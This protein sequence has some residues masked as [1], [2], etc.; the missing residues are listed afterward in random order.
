M[1]QGILWLRL[2]SICEQ[3]CGEHVELHI[4]TQLHPEIRGSVL[5]SGPGQVEILLN[6]ANAKDAD[7]VI[8]TLAHELAHLRTDSPEHDEAFYCSW[9]NLQETIDGL[10]A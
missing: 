9:D 6:A 3:L 5:R 2:Q 10:Y 7:A 4:S 1:K 8:L